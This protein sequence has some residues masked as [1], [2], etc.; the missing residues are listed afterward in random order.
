MAAESHQRN[1][2]ADHTVAELMCVR[3]QLQQTSCQLSDAQQM[4]AGKVSKN[5]IYSA[6]TTVT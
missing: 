5:L 2:A 1:V 3:T 4:L 6:P